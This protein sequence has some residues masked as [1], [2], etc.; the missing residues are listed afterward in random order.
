MAERHERSGEHHEGHIRALQRRELLRLQQRRGVGVGALCAGLAARLSESGTKAREG[1]RLWL[2]LLYWAFDGKRPTPVF[3]QIMCVC[4]CMCVT[5][6]Q[7]HLARGS[8]QIIDAIHVSGLGGRKVG[9]GDCGGPRVSRRCDRRDVL[10]RHICG[11][12]A[13]AH[14]AH[15]ANLNQLSRHC[16]HTHTH[17]AGGRASAAGATGVMYCA[18]IYAV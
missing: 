17:N 16:T 12:S 7:T 5:R 3:Y 4:V 8:L 9:F 15:N 6:K 14:K 13:T 18:G 10:C 11:V 1:M 2:L